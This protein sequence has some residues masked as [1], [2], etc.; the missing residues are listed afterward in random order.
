MYTVV[1]DMFIILWVDVFAV[2]VFVCGYAVCGGVHC[3]ERAPCTRWRSRYRFSF[4]LFWKHYSLQT[5][6]TRS[7]SLARTHARRRVLV[8]TFIF[9]CMRAN[10]AVRS[11]FSVCVWYSQFVYYF[12]GRQFEI[13]MFPRRRM[14]CR[15]R[16]RKRNA[17]KL[18]TLHKQVLLFGGSFEMISGPFT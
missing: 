8:A 14:K 7:P 4:S 1:H 18:N 12:R 9:V 11:E 5:T 15:Y 16:T 2:G 17:I 10:S 6:A 13:S 3:E